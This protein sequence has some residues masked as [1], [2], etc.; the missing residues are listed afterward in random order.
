M[1]FRARLLAAFTLA[2]A[3]PLAM[4]AFGVRREVTERLSDE[5][6]ERRRAQVRVAAED[7]RRESRQIDERLRALAQAL[8]D[9][10]RFRQAAVRGDA[11]A[12][13]YLLDYGTRAL[14]VSG[15]S[16]LQLQDD[17]GRILSSGHFRQE[18]D[19][20]DADLPR[21]LAQNAGTAT[22]VRARAPGGAFIALA[23]TDSVLVGGRWFVLIGGTELN[24]ATLGVLTRGDGVQI[25]LEVGDS[26]LI[27]AGSTRFANGSDDTLALVFVEGD[28][29]GGRVT[30][31]RIVIAHDGS[32]LDAMRRDVNRWFA[33]ALIAVALGVAGIA[34]W[35]SARLSRPL[36]QLAQ[37][38]SRIELSGGDAELPT[39]RDD[40]VGVL[41]RRL[42]ALTGRLREGARQLRDAE[43][44]A[45]VGE[46]ARQVNHDIKNGL[47]PIRNVLRHFGEIVERDPA[48]LQA[49]F[50][51]RRATLDSS[52]EYLDGLSRNYARLSPRIERQPLDINAI[53][54]E[55]AEASGADAASAKLT[56]SLAAGLPAV[57][58]DPVLL[59]R[60]L[61]NLLRNAIESLEGDP[62]NVRVA[63]AKTADGRV[64]ITISDT[65]RGMT[66]DE[67]ARAFDD[68]FTT[69]P[70]GTGLGLS[71]VRRLT[72]DL[73]GDI[74]SESMP[75]RGTTIS[76]QLTAYS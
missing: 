44:R 16:M 39:G 64:E 50:S 63:T 53:V 10:D 60:V 40:E 19:R 20:V 65:G 36:K 1:T 23:R 7:L 41:A 43:R 57:T 49:A 28:A 75:G 70:D 48:M 21:V 45:T 37:A 33:G 2:A 56:T 5:F 3:L 54:R 14:G 62:R 61:D 22:L 27:A 38:T 31:A 42:A 8:V 24:T 15:L 76:V 74:R 17:A 66:E 47:I 13:A 6:A 34:L 58:G 46:L 12:R 73:G 18:F 67:L 72:A 51:E 69:K 26:T 52:V 32:E 35:L 59:R 4:L 9:D 30:P 11:A 55:A 29:E 68:F 71:V 25:R